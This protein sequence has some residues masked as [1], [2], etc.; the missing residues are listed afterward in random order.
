MIMDEIVTDIFFILLQIIIS[1]GVFVCCSYGYKFLSKKIQSFD[2]LKSMRIFNPGEY[3]PDEEITEIQQIFYL[4]MILIFV[5]NILY[6]LLYWTQNQVVFIVMDI[7]ISI[8][9]ASTIDANTKKDKLIL[10]LLIPFNSISMLLLGFSYIAFLDFFHALLYFY[11]I[12]VYFDKFM[13]YTETNSLGITIMLLF[14]IVFVSFLFTIVVENVSPL[15]SMVM[16]SN[17][18]TSNGY[19]ILGKSAVGKIDEIFLVWSGFTL[20]GVAT[21]TLTV[22]IVMR[23]INESF[24]KL[25]NQVRKNRK[26]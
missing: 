19:A 16:V 13:E 14:L 22:A 26:K 10:F 7:V 24:D 4:A 5:F 6:L 21:A 3:F 18:F 8:Y 1:V 2:K 11:F 9:L 15:D 12:K 20:S 23:H 25:E 17:A